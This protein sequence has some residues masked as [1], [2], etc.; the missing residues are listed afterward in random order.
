MNYYM[1]ITWD[2][3]PDEWCLWKIDENIE[4]C[5]FIT[6]STNSTNCDD[7]TYEIKEFKSVDWLI[8]NKYEVLT[9]GEALIELL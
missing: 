2:R 8:T 5:Q 6:N 9:E 3:F 7:V 4:Y 1:K